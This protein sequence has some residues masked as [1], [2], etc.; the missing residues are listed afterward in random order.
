MLAN[1]LVGALMV[2]CAYVWIWH[3]VGVGFPV[4]S[5]TIFLY[6]AA[7]ALFIAD[8][9][10]NGGWAIAR[11]CSAMAAYCVLWAFSLHSK[12][13]KLPNVEWFVNDTTERV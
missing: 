1:A 10:F 12:K 7:F 3:W 4:S 13:S 5:L 6:G 2:F 8:M 9:R 11:I